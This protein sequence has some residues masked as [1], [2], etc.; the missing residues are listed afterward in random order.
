M[1]L[2]DFRVNRDVIIKAWGDPTSEKNG[3]LAW[4]SGNQYGEDWRSYDDRKR[5]W[6]DRASKRG[7]KTVLDLARFEQGKPPL[8]KGERLR[9]DEFISAWQYAFDQQ[10]IDKPPNDKGDWPPIRATFPYR[11]EQSDLL[12][13]VVRFNTE[14]RDE[15]FRQ[16][17]PDG[18]GGWIWKIKGTRIVLYRLPELIRAVQAGK[19]ILVCEGEKDANTALIKLGYV[20]TTMP[21]GVG[22]WRGDFDAFFAG[23][24]VVIVSDNDPQLKDKK[25]GVPMFH[26][27]GRPMLPGQ[28]HAAAV[29]RRLSKVA[30]HVRSIIFP[31]KDLTAW[32]EAGGTREQ[33]DAL[34]EQAP[35]LKKQPPPEPT[36]DEE[37]AAQAEAEQMLAELNRDNCVVLDGGKTMVLRF[38]RVEYSADGEHYVYEVPT[39]LRFNDLRNFFLNRRIRISDDKTMPLG[40]WWLAHPRRRQYA[41][42]VF[43]PKSPAIVRGKLNLWRGWGVEP[44]KGDWSLMYQHIKDVLCAGDEALYTY[45]L[46]WLAWSVQNPDKPA[47]VATVFIGER[48]V[49]KGTLGK[50]MCRIFG[51]HARH[52]TSADHLTGHFNAHLRQCSFLFGDEAYAPKDKGAESVLKAMITEPTLPIE[53][54]GRDR[55]EVPNCLHLMLAGNNDWVIPA[56]MHE[57]RFVVQKASDSKRQ[58]KKWFGPLYQQLANGGYGAMLYDLLEIGLGAWHPREI[59]RTAA[60]AE[61]QIQSLSALDE[62]WVEVLHTGVLVGA[63]PDEPHRAVSNRYEEDVS[64]TSLHGG[65]HTRRVRREGLFDAARASSPRLRSISDHAIGHYLTSKGAERARPQRRRGWQFPPLAHCRDEWVKNFPDTLWHDQGITEWQAEPED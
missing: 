22:K 20:A 53:P 30:A 11:D 46:N 55:I 2:P 58:D 18:K 63:D 56:G 65:T 39:F 29:A 38:E 37:R 31:Q 59:V 24:D 42:L 33:L 17:Q 13:E 40:A 6:Y 45:N 62:W 16:R 10:W 51:Q 36:E 26:P 9:G 49:G 41:G 34:I 4:S 8:R 50:T 12:F 47:E 15:R 5:L 27:D 14:D 43:E 60:L 32:V 61:Q 25:T 21:G 64:E 19:R 28:D 52:I 44:K 1:S 3:K 23:A 57:R 54:K 35:E 7:G 48:G